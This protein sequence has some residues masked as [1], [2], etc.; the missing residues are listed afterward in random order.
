MASVVATHNHR[1]AVQGKGEVLREVPIP[2]INYSG[3]YIYVYHISQLDTNSMATVS[4]T[5]LLGTILGMGLV[6]G[7][8]LPMQNPI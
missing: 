8:R 3:V 6:G 2:L 1:K 5:T 7:M 4:S